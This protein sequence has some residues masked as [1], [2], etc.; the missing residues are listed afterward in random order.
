VSQANMDG[1]N[2]DCPPAGQANAVAAYFMCELTKQG[3]FI[4]LIIFKILK[5]FL[6]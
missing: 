2:T 1:A 4:K 6:F 5:G 3:I